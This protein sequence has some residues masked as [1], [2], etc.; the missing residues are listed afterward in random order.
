MVTV[1]VGSKRSTA[2]RC[3]DDIDATLVARDALRRRKRLERFELLN[4]FSHGN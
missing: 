3:D 4:V 2:N 1:E